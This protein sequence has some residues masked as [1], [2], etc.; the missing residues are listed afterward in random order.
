MIG[1]IKLLLTYPLANLV[2]SYFKKRPEKIKMKKLREYLIKKSRLV[3]AS[4]SR[5]YSIAKFRKLQKY[6]EF[7]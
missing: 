5:E 1:L 7:F 2:T 3:S 4:K 6:F